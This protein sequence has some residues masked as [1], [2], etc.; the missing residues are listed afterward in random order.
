MT[1]QIQKKRKFTRFA[2]KQKAQYYLQERYGIWKECIIYTISCKGVGIT[3]K[4]I[5][6]VGSIIFLEIPM[7]HEFAPLSI[8]GTL[9]WIK[10]KENDFI[11]GIEFTKVLDEEQFSKL[12]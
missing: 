12:G 5:I 6:N 1:P 2:S 11:G 3:L 4:E 8:K 7:A 9:R 10:E